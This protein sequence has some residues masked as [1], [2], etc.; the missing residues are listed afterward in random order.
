[1]VNHYANKLSIPIVKMLKK[2]FDD[3]DILNVIT[4]RKVKVISIIKEFEN[5]IY[6]HIMRN[7]ALLRAGPD[8]SL[9]YLRATG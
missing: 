1:M 9:V 6:D 2:E 5:G 3:L 7:Y 8:T 4:P